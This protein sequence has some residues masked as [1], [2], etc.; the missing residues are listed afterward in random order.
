MNK[1][2]LKIFTILNKLH[3][4]ES[5]FKR[6]LAKTFLEY[7]ETL[8]IN[9]RIDQVESVLYETNSKNLPTLDRRLTLQERK[10]LLLASKGKEIKEMASILGLSQR[11]IKYHRANIIRKLEVPNLMAAV[12]SGMHCNIVNYFNKSLNFSIPYDSHI[13]FK[14]IISKMPGSVYWK[15]KE[16]VYLGCNDY[17]AEMAGVESTK[18]VIGKTD[19]EFSWKEEAAN[20]LKTEREIMESQVPRELEISGTLADGRKVT[21]LVIKT[22]LYNNNKK[23]SGILAT[24]LD[25]TERKKLE[26]DLKI[27]KEKAETSSQAKSEFIMNICQALRIALAGIIELYSRQANKAAIAGDEHPSQW[28]NNI[29]KQLLEIVNSVETASA[30]VLIDCLKKEKM[31]LLEFSKKLKTLIPSIKLN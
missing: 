24:S 4:Q 9:K 26:E 31:D 5:K 7:L 30:E 23:I 18:E 13:L 21:F 10:C 14:N 6:E 19:Y 20:I 22:P 25:I 12:A 16:G 28:V 1:K 8:P 17:V 11:T 27:A 2:S 29:C 15:N 3:E